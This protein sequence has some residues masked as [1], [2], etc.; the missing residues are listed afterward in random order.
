MDDTERHDA[1]DPADALPPEIFAQIL[2]Y[3][4]TRTLLVVVRAVSRRWQA[5]L[6]DVESAKLDLGF[7]GRT[8]GLR[9]LQGKRAGVHF[10]QA[11]QLDTFCRITA[12][13]FPEFDYLE[14]EVVGDLA[15]RCT[16]LTRLNLKG[17]SRI[18]NAAVTYVAAH[19]KQLESIDLRDCLVGSRQTMNRSFSQWPTLKE[20]HLG[21]TDRLHIEVPAGPA[22]QPYLR[23][24]LA[25]SQIPTFRWINDAA[26][27]DLAK[28][29][30][31]LQSVSICAFDVTDLGIA[32]LVEGCPDIRALDI[33]GCEHVT[34]E[35]VEAFIRAAGHR[36]V[37]LK[38]TGCSVTRSAMA[39]LAMQCPSL[40]EVSFSA[41]L[42]S[43]LA[44]VARHCPQLRH[45][46]LTDSADGLKPNAAVVPEKTPFLE[47]V[48]LET[49][50]FSP[51]REES[52]VSSVMDAW[53]NWI[54]SCVR[55]TVFRVEAVSDQMLIVL[56]DNCPDLATLECK[57]S[58]ISDV[59]LTAIGQ[60]CRLLTVLHVQ[61]FRAAPATDRG[62]MAIAE[63]CPRLTTLFLSECPEVTAVSVT[64]LSQHC[65][66]LS[67][68]VLEGSGELTDDCIVS[69]A[70]RCPLHT[71]LMGMQP[72]LTPVFLHALADHCPGLAVVEC[73][74]ATLSDE[75]LLRL[76]TDC[77]LIR[78]LNCRN[79]TGYSAATVTALRVGLGILSSGFPREF[80]SHPR[81]FSTVAE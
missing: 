75:S 78:R 29:C 43:E 22:E 50:C 51:P 27:L 44:S 60:R 55:L 38:F 25:N 40:E 8:A 9:R 57:S 62:V 67:K 24:C 73:P 74:G 10:A 46:A 66:A 72:G 71:L 42:R 11:L 15:R 58:L 68:V 61:P 39:S 59:G 35:G 12:L 32:R 34:D 20:V 17:C 81:R 64:A 37:R 18:T 52:V 49:G 69:L 3:L 1:A 28:H 14:D 19:C 33:T 70:E 80:S 56:A 21:M 31:R 26:M 4:D 7:L 53:S 79:T 76:I 77:P 45:I 48:R 41:G 36:A 47:S 2:E 23:L 5:A 65:P 16:Q 30:P 54:G 6:C 63:G 13:E